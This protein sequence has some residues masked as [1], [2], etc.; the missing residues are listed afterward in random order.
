MDIFTLGIPNIAIKNIGPKRDPIEIVQATITLDAWD[1]YLTKRWENGRE[2]ADGTITLD[3][4]CNSRSL[5]EDWETQLKAYHYLL[6][7]Q[8]EI[9][10]SIVN[11]VIENIEYLKG[12]LDSNDPGVP[13]ITPANSAD[14]DLRASIGPQSLSILEETKDGVAYL[15]W[16]LNCTWDVEHGL[17][18]TTYHERVIDIDRGETDIWKIF[19]DNGTLEEEER[20]SELLF[21]QAKPKAVKPWWKFW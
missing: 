5:P 7:H 18:A 4:A 9:R 20:K 21:K 13:N 12:Y 8:H 2:I 17:A 6:E 14:F 3:F 15:E 16:F 10:D 1:G 11:S 19:K